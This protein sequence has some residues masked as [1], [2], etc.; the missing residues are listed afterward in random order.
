[1]P[2][3]KNTAQKHPL[4]SRE[5]IR[6][7]AYE[8]FSRDGIRAVGVD[9]IIAEAGIAKMTLYRNYQSKDEL[10]I[11]FL[12][13]RR[14]LW[15]EEMLQTEVKRRASTPQQQLLAIF[16]VFS[17]WF[18]RPDF[19]GCPF[20]TTM[21]EINDPSHPVHQA[22]VGHLAAIR[23]FLQNLA[24]ATGISDLDSFAREWHLLM[25]GS[26]LAAHEGDA[27]AAKHARKLGEL[28]LRSYGISSDR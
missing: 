28:L 9:A 4:N 5:R 19:R 11:D 15:A 3:P 23:N 27:N 17:E 7:A 12:M 18:A 6:R 24:A 16:D 8:L 1:M 25:K 10:I 14:I 22:T 26:I 21:L 13:Q 2:E 20:I